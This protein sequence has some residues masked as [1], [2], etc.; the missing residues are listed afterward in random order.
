[1][2]A[3]SRLAAPAPEPVGNG[4]STAAVAALVGF[5]AIVAMLYFG[6]AV[7]VPIALAV[8]LS[9][10]LSPLILV[11]RRIRVPRTLSVA[12]VVSAA[13]FGILSVGTVVTLQVADLASELPRYQQ[14]IRDKIR[15]LKGATEG[16]GTF[17]RL[18]RMLQELGTEFETAAAPRPDSAPMPV[19][20][21]EP[22][23][24]P[25]AMAQTI[26]EPLLHPLGIIFVVFIFTIFILLQ[27]EDLR[28]R[29]IR[30]AGAHDIQ[31]TTAALDDAAARLSRFFLTQVALNAGF[32]TVIGIGLWI[33]GVPSPAL[34]GLLAAV[35]R[36]VPYVGAIVA[37][38]L[39]LIFAVAVDPGWTIVLST[40]LLFLIV[41]PLVGHIL[42]PL[43]YGR[44]T[45]LSPVA[46]VAAATFWTWLWGP[47][48]LV[49]ATPL[50]LCLV[51]LGRHVDQLDFLD[52]MLGDRP[53]L[54][55]PELF[56][57]RMLASDPVE[58]TAKAEEFLKEGTLMAYMDEVALPGLR[59]AHR[60]AE[61]GALTPERMERL[62]ASVAELLENL[63]YYDDPPASDTDDPEAEAALEHA[64]KPPASYPV[65]DP[66]RLPARWREGVPI[67]CIAVRSPLDHAA[68]DIASHILT[69]HGLASRTARAE[70]IPPASEATGVD[71]DCA[72]VILSSLETRSLALLRYSVR[73]I[74]RRL[75]HARIILA[76]WAGTENPA[77]RVTMEENREVDAVA[78]RLE[79]VVSELTG[80][81][82]RDMAVAPAGRPCAAKDRRAASSALA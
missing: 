40:A 73:R 31:R 62:E 78:S 71:D 82:A 54:S 48:G 61:R 35:L 16:S 22:E 70:D 17:D 75:P 23:Q 77:L 8:L 19:E 11:L 26:A 1:M 57:Q 41:E 39:P 36:F 60:D 37:A 51:V 76:A 72:V 53:A 20:I 81:A 14:T 65:I 7:F 58:A 6:R 68:A 55:G 24:G 2:D 9:F 15:T 80:I 44:S 33:I 45:G 49:L 30:L 5:I 43:L 38:L 28:N 27:R 12:L 34:W 56:Y 21:H 25:L 69:R 67:L 59:L 47:I 64:G 50:T 46:V 74:R 18:S 63:S 10:V 52:V 29:V 42:E 4:I 32:G 79:D 13:F 3:P 66:D